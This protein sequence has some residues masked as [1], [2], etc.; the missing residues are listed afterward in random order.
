MTYEASKRL[1][2]ASIGNDKYAP[3]VH[4]ASA[5]LGEIVSVD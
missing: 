2:G 4:M 1:L 5:S 3:L